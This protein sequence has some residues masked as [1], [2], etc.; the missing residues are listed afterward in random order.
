MNELKGNCHCRNVEFTRFTDKNAED[1]V[2][3]RCSLAIELWSYRPTRPLHPMSETLQMSRD[4]KDRGPRS[5][6][7]SGSRVVSTAAR[8]AGREDVSLSTVPAHVP[9]FFRRLFSSTLRSWLTCFLIALVILNVALMIGSW[10]AG[11]FR[12]YQEGRLRPAYQP[13]FPGNWCQT[14]GDLPC[15]DRSG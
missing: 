8:N 3:R 7:R 15:S 2:P 6:L 13:S 12:E 9:S 10:D 5:R 4:M 1:L 11:T 14:K